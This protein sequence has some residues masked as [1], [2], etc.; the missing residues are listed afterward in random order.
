MLSMPE[1]G[2]PSL[3]QINI[4]LNWFEEV[5]QKASAASLPR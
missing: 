2:S 1:G 3:A 4:V 5:K